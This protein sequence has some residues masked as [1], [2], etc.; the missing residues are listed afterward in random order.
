ML[1]TYRHPYATSIDLELC[2]PLELYDT[3]K[4]PFEES[5]RKIDVY[6]MYQFL[7]SGFE[8]TYDHSGGFVYVS[9]GGT[10]KIENL[11][12]KLMPFFN[13]CV[14]LGIY[15]SCSSPYHMSWGIMNQELYTLEP[16]R[17]M[18]IK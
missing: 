13:F 6:K 5:V 4:F 15:I 17:I 14:D 3:E 9:F 1:K 11:A 7:G 2:K 12:L 18:T 16:I 8:I 10:G